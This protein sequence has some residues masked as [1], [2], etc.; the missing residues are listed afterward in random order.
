M[1][2]RLIF[3]Q[4]RRTPLS[5]RPSFLHGRSSDPTK[6]NDEIF[7]SPQ[8][9]AAD[10][11]SV[12]SVGV[13]LCGALCDLTGISAVTHDNDRDFCGVHDLL[14]HSPEEYFTDGR[15]RFT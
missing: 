9:P 10:C 5:V 6:L 14:G 8:A 12:L 2:S 11:M 15:L 13:G 3:A 4:L 7:R 1:P